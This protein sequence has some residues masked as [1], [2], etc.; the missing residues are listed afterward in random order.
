MNAKNKKY[1]ILSP[2]GIAIDFNVLHYSSIKEVKQ[3]L[4]T[5]VKRYKKQG[6]YSSSKYGKIHFLDIADFCELI[7]LNN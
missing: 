6:Y 2:D 4:K 3:A 7:Q 1:Q 5:W